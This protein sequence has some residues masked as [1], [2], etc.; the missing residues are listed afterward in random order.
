MELAILRGGGGMRLT[1]DGEENF[2]LLDVV[3]T[4]GD[5]PH[6]WKFDAEKCP[7]N[8][9]VDDW[10]CQFPASLLTGLAQLYPE[11]APMAQF[12]TSLRHAIQITGESA[13]HVA[14]RFNALWKESDIRQVLILLDI[15][16]VIYERKEFRTIGMPLSADIKKSR[17]GARLHIIDKIISENYGQKITLNDMAL[18]VGMSPTS[19]CNAFKAM[20]ATTFNKYLTDYRMRVASRLLRD[21]DLNISEIGYQVGYPD[22]AHFSRAFSARFNIS[23]SRF[24]NQVS[25]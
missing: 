2:G 16:T 14:E 12:F 6:C 23:P 5:M 20:T 19:F 13:R 11:F 22:V 7:P 15:F 1:N 21:T 10:S 24:R 25:I 9:L 3:F 18:A 17:T 4:P 8:G